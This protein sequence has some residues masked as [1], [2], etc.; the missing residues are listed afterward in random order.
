MPSVVEDRFLEEVMVPDP[1]GAPK[2]RFEG[3][4]FV[5]TEPP[6]ARRRAS[7]VGRATEAD[8]RT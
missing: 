1:V 4:G 7:D 2:I 3:Q 6:R 8:R 5:L